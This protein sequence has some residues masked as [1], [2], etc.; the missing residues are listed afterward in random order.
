MRAMKTLSQT[1]L[2]AKNR[3]ANQVATEF[4]KNKK[5]LTYNWR[6]VFDICE[7]LALALENGGVKAGDRVAIFSNTRVEWWL[8]DLAV[9][10]MGAVTVPVYQSSTAADLAFILNNSRTKVL[11]LEDRHQLK[12]WESIANQCPSVEK[13][14]LF[15]RHDPALAWDDFLQTGRELAAQNSTFE[16]NIKKVKL[17]NTATILYTSGTTGQPKGVVLTHR[18]LMSELE[19]L[20][21]VLGVSEADKTL[22]FLPYAH[23]VGRVEALGSVHVGY[24]LAFAESLEKMRHNLKE[25]QPTALI[26]VPRIF[27]KIYG[28]IITQIEAHPVKKN[29]FKWA[30]TV[31]KQLSKAKRENRT[32]NPLLLSEYWLADRLVF[33]QFREKMGGRLRFAMCGG[34][35]L[36]T[37]ISELFHAAGILILEGYGL[38]ETTGAVTVNTPFSY[39]F[40]TV[41]RPFGDVEIRL[42]QDG[43]ILV[44]SDKVMTSYYENQ[45]ATDEVLKEGFFAT[46]DIGEWTLDGFLKITD[47]KKDLIKTAGGKYVAPQKLENALKLYPLISNVHIHGDQRKYIVALLTLNRQMLIDFAKKHEISYQDV[48]ALTQHDR[49]RSLVRK[50]VAD[51]NSQLG[52]YES[53]KAFSILLND[54]S[55]DSGELTPSLKVK[56]K[57]CDIKYKDTINSL[58]GRES[59]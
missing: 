31:G 37:E 22:S 57:Y 46:G 44:K 35:P 39:D 47:R 41:G 58:Y 15:E 6:E 23:I 45:D 20:F 51:V 5:W 30:L 38:S 9:L 24:T 42:A 33:S 48:A 7:G 4:K 27:E 54:F 34:A 16:Q 59:V 1:L 10:G 40:G 2:D 49:I 13:V 29:L 43:E 25:V 36:A 3:P 14:I 21:P 56:R 50:I 28:S 12:K 11:V 18:Q 55:V 53:I 19:D 52:S 8:T 32:I 17:E 26:G